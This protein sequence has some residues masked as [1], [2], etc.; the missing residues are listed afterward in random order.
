MPVPFAHE[1]DSVQ[2]NIEMRAA[3]WRIWPGGVIILF[4]S[5]V[6]GPRRPWFGPAVEREWNPFTAKMIR[7]SGAQVVPI[8]FPGQNSRYYQIAN[9]ISATLRQGLLLHEVVHALNKPQAP[10]RR[11]PDR[12]GRHRK[13]AAQSARLRGVAARTHARAEIADLTRQ[14]EFLAEESPDP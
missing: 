1:A 9:K 10:R 4:P 13:L 6:G 2:Q 3:R 5:G 8:Y 12:A 11:P 7:R 14:S